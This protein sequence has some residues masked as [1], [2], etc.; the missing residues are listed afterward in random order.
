MVCRFVFSGKAEI[1]QQHAHPENANKFAAKHF[2]GRTRREI[3][4][5]RRPHH[6]DEDEQGARLD[7]VKAVV[8]GFCQKMM[9][10]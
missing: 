10:K 2:R 7:K 5:H 3:E 1:G 4:E 8:A 9:Q 6:C